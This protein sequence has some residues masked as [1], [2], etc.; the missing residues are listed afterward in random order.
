MVKK[1]SKRVRNACVR[2]ATE[3]L[4]IHKPMGSGMALMM[5]SSRTKPRK[6]AWNSS[7]KEDVHYIWWHASH[8]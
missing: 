3:A 2:S 6:G 8:Y 5:A 4:V 7:N 1:K